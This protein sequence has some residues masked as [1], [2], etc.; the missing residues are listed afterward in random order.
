MLLSLT[1][2][3]TGLP[4]IRP[5]GNTMLLINMYVGVNTC[6]RIYRVNIIN[7]Y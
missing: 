6:T 5:K 7:E 2:P 3:K 4:L 1:K